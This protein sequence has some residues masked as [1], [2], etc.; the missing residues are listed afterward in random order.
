LFLYRDQI[1]ENRALEARFIGPEA[2]EK[3]LRAL[4]YI[5]EGRDYIVAD[6]DS[7]VRNNPV[8]VAELIMRYRRE[9]PFEIDELLEGR[10]VLRLENSGDE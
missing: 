1:F 2:G 10:F 4:G 3:A 6:I 9:I 5:A 7:A 8:R